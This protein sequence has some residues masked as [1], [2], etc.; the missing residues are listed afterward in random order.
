MSNEKDKDAEQA[1]PEGNTDPDTPSTP[2]V[3]HEGWSAEQIAEQ[4]AYKDGTEVK[5]ELEEGKET[6]QQS[7]Q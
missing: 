7:G 4:S 2:D 3:K 6:Q 1:K 5:E